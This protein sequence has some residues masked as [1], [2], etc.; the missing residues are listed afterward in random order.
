M[1]QVTGDP[2]VLNTSRGF[3]AQEMARSAMDAEMVWSQ[4]AISSSQRIAA[5]L[6]EDI[7]AHTQRQILH[8]EY[9]Q[10]MAD[11]A[12]GPRVPMGISTIERRDLK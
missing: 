8:A 2:W 6:A 7:Q 5:M 1:S 11:R 4:I 3:N 10:R 12:K 9:V